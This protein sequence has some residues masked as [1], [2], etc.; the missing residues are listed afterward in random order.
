MG[1]PDYEQR[2]RDI[3]AGREPGAAQDPNANTG[4]TPGVP[5]VPGGATAGR[6]P[7]LRLESFATGVQA[8]GLADFLKEA[9][10][11]MKEGKFYSALDQYDLAEQVAPNN[12]LV[13]LGRAVA[14]LGASYYARADQHLREAFTRDPALLM[15]QYDLKS[16]LGQERLEFVVNDLRAIS[17]RETNEP[18]SV[19]LLAFIDYNTGN[20]RRAAA[21]LDL[22]EKRAGKPDPLFQNL[23][24]Y[25]ELPAAGPEGAAEDA[26]K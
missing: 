10:R 22:A 19:F 21:Y 1:L 11:L 26:N 20:P 25:W 5:G 8:K 16:F 24:K 13:G 14:E 3:L 2:N 23:R 6:E 18:R 15:A 7:P 12:P 17:N 9:E 4:T